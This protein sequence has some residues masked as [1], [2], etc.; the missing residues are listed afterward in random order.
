MGEARREALRVVFDRSIKL[1]F[2]GAKVTGDAGLLPYRELDE[3]VG[4]TAVAEDSLT[5]SRTGDNIQQMLL[6]LLRQSIYSRLGG[7]E[8]TND[9]DRLR[10]GPT[11]R[12]IVAKR[13]A[14]GYLSPYHGLMG[15]KRSPARTG[16]CTDET[17]RPVRIAE[18]ARRC[19]RQA[20]DGRRRSSSGRIDTSWDWGSSPCSP[21]FLK[22]TLNALDLRDTASVAPRFWRRD[23]QTRLRSGTTS[24]G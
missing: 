5:D 23:C 10:L 3:S 17:W 18:K 8:D 1:E 9:A 22:S 6:A 21:V 7:Y 20:S 11:M 16:D 24:G 4:L 2:H 19:C 14:E 12:V 15:D 13:S